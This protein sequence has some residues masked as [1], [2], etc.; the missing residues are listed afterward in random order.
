MTKKL[1]QT[2]LQ[3]EKYVRDRVYNKITKRYK[4]KNNN[5]IKQ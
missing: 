5:K 3:R 4:N 1:K 2:Y